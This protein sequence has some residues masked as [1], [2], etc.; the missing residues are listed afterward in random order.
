MKLFF[1]SNSLEGKIIEKAAKLQPSDYF[2]FGSP[3][4]EMLK[5]TEKYQEFPFDTDKKIFLYAPTWRDTDSWSDDF[6][7]S[8]KQYLELNK[9][10]KSLN[11]VFLIKQHPLTNIKK[12]QEW[13]LVESECIF[14]T[15]KL[16]VVD[17]NQILSS[18][19]FLIT[20]V[21]SVVF[22]FLVFKKPF[23]FFMPD[24]K[25]YFKNGRGVY[26][27]F[28]DELRLNS[29]KNWDDLIGKL[30]VD[31]KP[32]VG[33]F[34]DISLEISSLDKVNYKIYQEILKRFYV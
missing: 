19:D 10:L 3:R 21:S 26:D 5:L 31:N 13:G 17:I 34:E 2:C 16:G 12:I 9:K 15:D 18:V 24:F 22:D 25:D 32:D 6:K 23:V 29:I 8:S 7:I 11:S 30:N 27:Y 1:L 20:D 28:K 14:Y 33:F 4:I